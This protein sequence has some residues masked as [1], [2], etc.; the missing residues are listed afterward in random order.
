MR[1]TTA[2]LRRSVRR[3]GKANRPPSSRKHQSGLG[4]AW[5]TRGSPKFRGQGERGPEGTSPRRRRR[6]EGEGQTSVESLPMAACAQRH[7]RSH[8]LAH[9]CNM[10]LTRNARQQEGPCPRRKGGGEAG[11]GAN[12]AGRQHDH[13]Q[14][15]PRAGEQLKRTGRTTATEAAP[16]T[17]KS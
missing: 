6:G 3:S 13:S 1:L 8:R 2:K 9:Q 5:N 4:G 11:E 17:A 15:A 10:N 7:G 16:C 14:Q 12:A